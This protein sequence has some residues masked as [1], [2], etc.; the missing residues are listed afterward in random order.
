MAG[1]IQLGKQRRE[2]KPEWLKVRMPGGGRYEQVRRTLRE[3]NLS[4]V[5]EEASCPNMGEC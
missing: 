5:C 2:P 4:T 1:L 3:L